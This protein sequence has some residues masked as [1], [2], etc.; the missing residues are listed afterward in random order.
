[1]RLVGPGGPLELDDCPQ[2]TPG[3]GQLLIEVEACAVC[4]TDLHLLDGELPDIPYPVVPGHQVVGRVV[5]GGNG[6]PRPGT[7]VGVPWLGYTCG[8]CAYCRSGRENL[9]PRARFTG[10]TLP[11]GFAEYLVADARYC[12]EVDDNADAA[13]VA[14][15]LCA[16][17]IGYRALSRCGDAERIG[18]YGFGA[19]A[20]IVAQIIRY[21]GRRLY[22][23]SR[24]GDASAMAAA[25]ALGAEW[26]GGSD[27]APP[28]RLDAAI[29]FA[30][31]G[32][33]VP[34]ALADVV[35]GG[36]VVCGGIHMSD[37]PSFAYSLLWGERRIE[38]IA[39]LT[40]ADGEQLLALA[41]E[42]PIETRV[43]CYAL[44]HVNE[45]LADLRAG[46][47]N[48]SAVLEIG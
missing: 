26:A 21:Q 11:G 39:N 17:M 18:I 22:A 16:G 42:I 3:H 30:P 31:V 12:F 47:L 44:E 13:A 37:I 1:M 29:I 8:E 5:S 4:R 38:S 46:A 27:E 28:E 19:A 32:A 48:G 2:P 41:A 15:L 24:P 40:R 45:A 35:A 7:R 9:C 33:L 6:S 34:K 14:P 20:H 36:A 43:R 10:Y 23:F 25:R